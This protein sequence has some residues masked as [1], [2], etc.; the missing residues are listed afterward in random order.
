MINRG[1]AILAASVVGVVLLATFG[2]PAVLRHLS[3]FR[4]RQIEVVGNRYLDEYAIVHQLPLGAHA[5]TFDRLDRIRA[6]VLR[7]PGVLDASV[8]RRLPGTLRVTIHEASPVALAT[9]NDRLGL[10]DSTAR[11]L[12][13]D[14]TR[15]PT[16]MPIAPRD[17]STAALLGRVMA[18]DPVLYAA[19]ESASV[20]HGDVILDLG[21]RRVLLRAN[22]D[23][24]VLQAIE[25]VES[26]L[27][28]QQTAWRELDARFSNR[29]FVRKGAA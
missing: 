4:V 13:F 7:I 26:Y 19:I 6:A 23:E 12:P 22:A 21:T 18:A 16:S 14:P 24:G 20:D 9:I 10:I 8:E 2:A 5:S 3:F 11:A 17:S 27:D 25:A 28:A 1:L 15:V 29:V